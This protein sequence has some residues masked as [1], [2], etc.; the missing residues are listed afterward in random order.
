MSVRKF[1]A[2]HEKTK[3]MVTGGN[4]LIFGG[5]TDH[6]KCYMLPSDAIVTALPA[7]MTEDDMGGDLKAIMGP[8][9]KVDPETVSEASGITDK[10]GKD[11]FAGDVVE[12]RYDPKNP[13]DVCRMVVTHE[14][15]LWK[16][17]EIRSGLVD[18]LEETDGAD[19]VVVGNRWENPELL[20]EG[21]L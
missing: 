9:L 19:L 8:I 6:L 20:M 2:I 15:L 18:T 3:R 14:G 11:I 13:D 1:R 16:L 12:A 4:I 17:T 21:K 10:K 5:D 7:R